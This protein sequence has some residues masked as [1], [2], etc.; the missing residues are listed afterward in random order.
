MMMKKCQGLNLNPKH[1]TSIM[2]LTLESLTAR[3]I[4]TL[5]L[6]ALIK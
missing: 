4:R 1:V 3:V 2:D 6:S 5:N